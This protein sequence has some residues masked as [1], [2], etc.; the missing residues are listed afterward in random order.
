MFSIR[1]LRLKTLLSA[2]VP[3]ALVLVAM[4]LIVLYEYGRVAQD[5]VEQRDTELARVSAA[6]LSEGLSQYSRLL[7]E[8]AAGDDV[9]S[10]EP[11]RLALASE[12]AQ[13]L[14]YVFDAGLAVY[15]SEGLALAPRQGMDFPIPSKL[16]EMRRTL[17]PVFSDVFQNEISGEDVMLIGV[18][19][20]GSDG[21]LKGVL[22]GMSTV[23][24]SLLGSTYA[25]ML[26]FKA[27]R[28]GYAYLVDGNGQ[29]VYHRHSSQVGGSLADTDPVYLLNNLG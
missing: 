8:I 29:V 20:V 16:D 12:E 14:L 15:D 18:P 1:S 3:M 19:I 17:R 25:E 28:S 9:R 21:D 6:R 7:Q 10:M 26:E 22:A 24:Y 27:G 13:D 4:A 11:A 2:L 5:V 23:K